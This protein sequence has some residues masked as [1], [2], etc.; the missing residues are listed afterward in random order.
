MALTLTRG[1]LLRHHNLIGGQWVEA[2][3]R[4][5]YAVTN[6]ATNEIITEAANSGAVDARAA[7]DAAAG[8]FP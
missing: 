8:A 3:G 1:D 6:P 4:A 5:R 2:S 7:T